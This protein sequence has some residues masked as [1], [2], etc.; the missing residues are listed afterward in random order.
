MVRDEQALRAVTEGPDGVAA[1]AAPGLAVLEMSTVGPEPVRRLAELLPDGVELLDAPVL[2][3]VAAAESGTLEVLVGGPPA[4]V[5]RC[6]PILSTLGHVRQVGPLGAG[7]AAKLVAN[8]ALFTVLGALGETLA[9]ADALGL[10][11]ATAFDILAATPL[12]AQAEHRRE[13]IERSHYPPRFA[14][15]LAHKD[16]RLIAEAGAG[17]DL[18][19]LDAARGWLADAEAAGAA[20]ADYTAVLARIL[21]SRSG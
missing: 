10:P 16:A 1:G 3:S 19:M 20:D 13:A 8:A 11:R 12:A 14:L 18:R 7:A 9:L 17:A 4:A 21:G 5:A 15:S 2:G 6:T